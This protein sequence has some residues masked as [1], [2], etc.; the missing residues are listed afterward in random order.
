MNNQIEMSKN[1]IIKTKLIAMS[2][3]ISNNIDRVKKEKME[4]HESLVR[5]KE[6]EMQKW[7]SKAETMLEVLNLLE[8]DLEE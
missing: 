2:D 1:Q 4:V 3:I 6:L 7:I 8:K 5:L